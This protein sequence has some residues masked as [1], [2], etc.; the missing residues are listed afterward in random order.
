MLSES[1]ET[2]DSEC[3][4]AQGSFSKDVT[5]SNGHFFHFLKCS[6]TQFRKK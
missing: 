6:K 4:E 5:G 2:I 1:Q 3:S